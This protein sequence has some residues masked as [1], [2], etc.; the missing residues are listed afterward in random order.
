MSG[1]ATDNAAG[2]RQMIFG[3]MTSQAIFVTATLGLADLMAK[4]AVSIEALAMEARAHGPS[5]ARL[6]HALVALGLAEEPE[7]G[8]FRT[9]SLGALLR[10][11]IPGS[12]RNVALMHGSEPGW[13]AW[14]NLL[15]AVRTGENAFKHVF[16]MGSFQHLAREPERAALFN[17]YMPDLTRPFVTAILAAH[18]FSR[19][20]RIVDVG[21][22]NGILL[23]SILAIAP[24]AEGLIFDTQTGIEGARQRLEEAGVAERCRSLAG[25]FFEAVPEAADAY[26]LKSVLH[27]WDDDRAVDIL[28]SCH[29]A[30][31]P[32]STLLV[33]ERLLPERIECI[34]AHRD[35]VMM[36]LH[37]L[38]MP[39]GRERT[40][41]Q[42]A[43]LLATA[44]LLSTRVRPT[45]SPFAVMEVVRADAHEAGRREEE[46]GEGS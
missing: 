10:S 20:R 46:N 12:L 27:N 8:H 23:S 16:G 6:L 25:D 40:T 13:R 43:K 34:G 30:M 4:D 3:Y 31:G 41:N 29:R 15:H 24:A 37:M 38:V 28:N 42:Y 2:L 35:I 17:A 19:Y 14:A 21:G 36:D 39:G 32:H 45:A 11:G 18:D 5:L 9:T 26:I 7:T 22:G 44:G 1:V 33:V